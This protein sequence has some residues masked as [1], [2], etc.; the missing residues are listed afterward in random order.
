MQQD[1]GQDIRAVMNS[2]ATPFEVGD[3]DEEL[4]DDIDDEKYIS[5]AGRRELDL[6]KPLVLSFAREFLVDDYDEVGQI[7]SR[8]GAY[9]R[10]KELLVRR[11]ALEPWY[12]FSNKAE[13]TALREW[14]AENGIEPSET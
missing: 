13:E 7:F 8:R 2:D 14:C 1:A 4:P 3:N 10:Y 6:G 9:R 12:D 5:I 11:G